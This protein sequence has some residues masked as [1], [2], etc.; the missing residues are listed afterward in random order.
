MTTITTTFNEVSLRVEKTGKC[1]TC[2]KRRKRVEKF[3]QTLNP[4]NKKADGTIK[5]PFDIR[6]EIAIEARK[7]KEKPID[8]CNE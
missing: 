6:R 7:W 4:F 8:C 5:N 1:I 3:W 2:G